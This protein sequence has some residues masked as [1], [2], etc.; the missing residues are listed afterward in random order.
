MSSYLASLGTLRPAFAFEIISGHNS[1]AL[2]LSVFFFFVISIE[3]RI[4][5]NFYYLMAARFQRAGIQSLP[6][7]F[8][9]WHKMS[10]K[11]GITFP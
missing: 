5:A 10:Q 2:Q 3:V 9:S 1:S 8:F 7:Y 6:K 4:P 11:S